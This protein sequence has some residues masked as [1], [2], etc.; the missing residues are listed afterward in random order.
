M[1]TESLQLNL[2]ADF[3]GNNVLRDARPFLK[4]VG[5]KQQLMAQFEAYFPTT[6]RRYCE[7]FVGG[8]AVFFHL[9]NAGRLT[10]QAFLF[11]N[12]AE[13]VNAYLVVRDKV[14]ELVETLTI[15]QQI[16]RASCRESV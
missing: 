14:D 5:G 13:L 10:R 2:P 16:G 8:G 6:F 1:I 7:P 11:D 3:L 12:N 4:W 9:W 15:H